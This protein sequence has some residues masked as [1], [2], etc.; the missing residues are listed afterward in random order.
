M[1]RAEGRA[2]V[3]PGPIPTFVYLCFQA[4]FTAP[5]LFQ[6]LWKLAWL[7]SHCF[8][9][10]HILTACNSGSSYLAL[11]TMGI[12]RGRAKLWPDLKPSWGPPSVSVLCK[13]SLISEISTNRRSHPV[14]A[15]M[16]CLPLLFKVAICEGASLPHWWRD[17]PWTRSQ[18]G[19]FKL[20]LNKPCA[21]VAFPVG[22]CWAHPF[23]WGRALQIQQLWKYSRFLLH[24]GLFHI[25]K[26][27]N[28]TKPTTN[29]QTKYLLKEIQ[30]WRKFNNRKY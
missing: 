3:C 1:T 18:W 6:N 28:K 16:S 8:S 7:P 19:L 14:R 26:K 27:P 10:S 29:R 17:G 2:H 13:R 23:G 22:P 21:S 4:T 25:K 12:R 11:W 15:T 30:I 20:R 5:F 24:S 9:S